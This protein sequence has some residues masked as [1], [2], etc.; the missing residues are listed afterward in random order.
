MTKNA[1]SEFSGSTVQFDGFHTPTSSLGSSRDIVE[2]VAATRGLSTML[3][4]IKAAGLTAKLKREGPFTVFAPS[5][6]A[7]AQL[8][9]ELM[10]DL[11][12]DENHDDLVALVSRHVMS[13]RLLAD[14]IDGQ[15]LMAQSL[16][17]DTLDIDATDG[18]HVNGAT[19][20]S[21]VM[22][23]SN[24]GIYVINTVLELEQDDEDEDDSNDDYDDYRCDDWNGV[25]RLLAAA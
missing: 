10:A 3:K 22:V 7:F 4:A 8:P 5:D 24:G 11:L 1:M 23:C 2:T 12:E 19:V 9:E 17:G 18:L 13:G 21:A 25:D 16:T 6:D 14:Y 20:I 15:S